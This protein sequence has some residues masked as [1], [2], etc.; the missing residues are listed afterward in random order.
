MLRVGFVQLHSSRRTT[1]HTHNLLVTHEHNNKT[2][3]SHSTLTRTKN[4][5]AKQLLQRPP[6][7]LLEKN[8]ESSAHVPRPPTKIRSRQTHGELTKHG[9][10]RSFSNKMCTPRSLIH[11]TERHGFSHA[12]P[13]GA[14]AVAVHPLPCQ[15]STRPRCPRSAGPSTLHQGDPVSGLPPD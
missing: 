15:Q 5:I 6:C 12:T 10:V 14:A 2:P 11:S 9:K 3:R 8:R 7:H 1:N 13:P 4:V